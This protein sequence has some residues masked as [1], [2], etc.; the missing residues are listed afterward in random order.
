MALDAVL[1]WKAEAARPGT[2]ITFCGGHAEF[3]EIME[4][5]LRC[6]FVL[7]RRRITMGAI[8]FN[9]RL[10]NQQTPMYQEGDFA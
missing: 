2:M 1:E 10:S 6:A 9:G 8:G 5:A 3:L 7:L 4:R